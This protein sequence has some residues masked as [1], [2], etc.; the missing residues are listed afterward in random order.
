MEKERNSAEHMAPP[1][2]GGISLLVIFAILCLTVF[3]LLSLSTVQ[4]GGRLSQAGSSAAEEYYAA[5]AAAE[6]ILASLREGNCPAG[7]EELGDGYYSY[8]CPI[9]EKRTLCCQVRVRSAE[10]YEVLE[11]RIEAST[12]EIP[13]EPLPVWPGEE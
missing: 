13:E 1:A 3:S 5:D 2:V 12:G 8:T 7:V 6:E 11:W 9:S 10:E 4:A